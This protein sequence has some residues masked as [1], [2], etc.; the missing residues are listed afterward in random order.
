MNLPSAPTAP[1]DDEEPREKKD[2]F[3]FATLAGAIRKGSYLT[4]ELESGQRIHHYR[5]LESLGI[6][7]MGQIFMAE[8]VYLKQKVALK[9]LKT[10]TAGSEELAERFLREAQALAILNGPNVLKVQDA[11]VYEG[12][13]YV[14]TELLHGQTLDEH[15]HKHGPLTV[16]Q[17][18][19]LLEQMGDVLIRQEKFGILH[20]D[21]KPQ[22]IWVRENGTFCLIDYGLV[23]FTETGPSRDL[24]GEVSTTGAVMGTP[25]YMAPEQAK[26]HGRSIDHRADL[27]GLGVTTWVSLT[28]QLPR[29]ASDIQSLLQEAKEE[30][31]RSVREHRADVTREFARILDSMTAI[32]VDDRYQTTKIFMEDLEAYRYGR[33]R[34]YGATSG[35]VFVAIPFQTSFDGL[36]EFLQDVCGEAKLAARRV[37]RVSNMKEVWQQIDKEIRLATIVIAVFSRERWR[38]APNANVLTEAAHARAIGR[39]LVVLT[40]D[41]AEDLPFDWRHLPIIRYRN[42]KQGLTKLREELLPRLLQETREQGNR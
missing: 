19:D 6:G 29:T 37:D 34:P 7:G 2:T 18:L 38:H 28:G 11:S 33:R 9:T 10:A 41:R 31:I 1:G 39:P 35:S 15:L 20:R 22:N 8:H 26:G 16:N 23:G 17:A 12:I 27:F 3:F 42:S 4:K 30:P 14:V 25:V 40:T 21:I 24:V 32:N 13:P 5:I 36:F